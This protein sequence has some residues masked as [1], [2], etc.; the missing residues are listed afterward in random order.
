MPVNMPT[1]AHAQGY[2]DFNKIIPEFTGDLH[3]KKGPYYADEGD[4]AT[5]GTV[6]VG[7]VSELPNRV[8]VGAGQDGYRRAL[9]D[10]YRPSSRRYLAGS[11]RDLPQQWVF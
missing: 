10:W 8:D 9:M 6:R 7:V 3:Y 1:H 11:R 5:A 4:F 2:S